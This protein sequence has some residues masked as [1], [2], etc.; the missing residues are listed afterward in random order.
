[1]GHD[2]FR[3]GAH[4]A[5]IG[6]LVRVQRGGHGNAHAVA[7]GHGGKVRGGAQ[8]AFLH[9]LF[10]VAVYH[11][12]DVVVSLIDHIHLL[13]LHVKADHMETGLGLFHRE[14]KPDIAQSNH[15]KGDAYGRVSFASKPTCFHSP[16]LR[17]KSPERRHDPWFMIPHGR[18]KVNLGHRRGT[19]R[20]RIPA[21][22]CT[23]CA[24]YPR[25]GQRRAQIRDRRRGR[26]AS[27]RGGA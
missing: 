24:F 1:M 23:A 21:G 11:V 2:A 3:R 20:N 14:R 18:R 6:L 7:R 16:Y 25:G 5:D 12:A 4:I 15:A 17:M 27:S 13:G 8:H 26:T 9:D 22:R 19:G 10:Q